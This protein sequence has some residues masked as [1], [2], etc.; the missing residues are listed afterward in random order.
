MQKKQK[1]PVLT[2][3]QRKY[4]RGLGHHLDHIVIVGREGLTDNLI[5]SCN[6]AIGAHELI[7]IKLGQNSPLVKN[8]AAAQ[9]ANKTGSVLV[10]LIGKTVLLYKP[11]QNK[12][13]D[14]QIKLPAGK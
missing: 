1:I 12:A 3:R 4:L 6:D 14:E 8:E 5:A 7:K 13:P 10:Q 9:L 11:N 2:G